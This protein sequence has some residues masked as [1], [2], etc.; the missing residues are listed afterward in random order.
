MDTTALSLITFNKSEAHSTENFTLDDLAQLDKSDVLYWI[1][2]E[3]SSSKELIDAVYRTFAVPD[4]LRE[5]MHLISTQRPAVRFFDDFL[6]FN[7]KMIGAKQAKREVEPERLIMLVGSTFIFTLQEGKPGDVFDKV[8]ERLLSGR[9]KSRQMRIDFLCYELLDAIIESFYQTLDNVGDEIEKFEQSIFSM[10]ENKKMSGV[11]H[12][13]RNNLL[14]VRKAVYP[15]RDVIY[16]LERL[17]NSLFQKDTE[18]YLHDLY[19]R[20]MQELETIDLYRELLASLQDPYLSNLSQKLNEIM[21]ILTIITTIFIP[22]SFITGFYGMNVDIPELHYRYTYAGIVIVIIL[23]TVG[24][25]AW[26][27]RKKWI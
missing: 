5:N 26:F 25:L 20:A 13:I 8:R 4:Y 6:L 12:G 17:E 24:M 10:K 16:D 11:L 1:N 21:K 2:A 18:M 7:L 3:G 22:L 27:R 19:N 14:I 15:L 23:V 9:S